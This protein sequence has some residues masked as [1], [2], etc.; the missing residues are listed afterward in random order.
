M[1]QRGIIFHNGTPSA[2]SVTC[3]ILEVLGVLPSTTSQ[4]TAL[5]FLLQA[6]WFA[7]SSPA[8]SAKGAVV[9]LVRRRFCR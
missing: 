1:N 8:V 6:T 7:S 4:D 2:L 5:L 3:S 9:A